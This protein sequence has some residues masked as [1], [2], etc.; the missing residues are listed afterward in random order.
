V[1][2]PDTVISM[3]DLS[4][5]YDAGVPCFMEGLSLDIR[6]E[7]VCALLGPNGSGKTTLLLLILGMLRPLKGELSVCGAPMQG[8]HRAPKHLVGLVPQEESITF[9]LSVLEYVLLGRAPHLGIFEQPG[10]SD[11]DLALQALGMV[12]ILHLKDREV[13]TLSGGERQLAMVA[14]VLVQESRILLMDEP[15]SHLDLSNTRRVLDL[16][17]LIRQKGKTVIFSTHDPN[18]A[19]AVAD[20]VVLMKRGA[21][22][23]TG[24]PAEVLTPENLREIYG[25]DVEVA[26]VKGRPLVII[27]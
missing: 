12:G 9:G 3:R 17:R 11:R 15:T 21:V 24:S 10:K 19:S 22:F 25:V 23:S 8:K 18:A 26:Q 2:R 4:F 20:H 14:R 5:G 6:E 13:P 1:S 16:I 7:S 27:E